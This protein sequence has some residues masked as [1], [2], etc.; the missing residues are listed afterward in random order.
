MPYRNCFRITNLPESQ[1]LANVFTRIEELLDAEAAAARPGAPALHI[2][3]ATG[4][5]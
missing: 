1:V 5:P 4:G 3:G 2:V